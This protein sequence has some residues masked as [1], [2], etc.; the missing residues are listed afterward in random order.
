MPHCC[1]STE[2]SQWP[3][4]LNASLTR[5]SLCFFLSFYLC[6]RHPNNNARRRVWICVTFSMPTIT[7]YKTTCFCV[8]LFAAWLGGRCRDTVERA[9]CLCFFLFW[10]RWCAFSEEEKKTRPVCFCIGARLIGYWRS[11]AYCF[12]VVGTLSR[13]FL[14][15]FVFRCRWNRIFCLLR[16]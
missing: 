1:G 16:R 5:A 2:T 10:E 9:A 15:F 8:A 13:L 6:C 12:V 11:R 4:L 3:I 7:R 14:F